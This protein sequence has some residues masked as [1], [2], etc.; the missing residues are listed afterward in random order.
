MAYSKKHRKGWI[1]FRCFAVVGTIL[2]LELRLNQSVGSMLSLVDYVDFF[3]LCIQEH[4]E[5]VA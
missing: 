4:V 2:L 5:A 1:P 3:G